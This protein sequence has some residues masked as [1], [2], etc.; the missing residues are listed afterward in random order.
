MKKENPDNTHCIYYITKSKLHIHVIKRIG[1]DRT[2]FPD[3]LFSSFPIIHHS[4]RT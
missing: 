4:C 1:A 3:P 2:D